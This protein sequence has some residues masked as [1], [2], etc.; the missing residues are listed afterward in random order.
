M[1]E[2]EW[3]ATTDQGEAR[4]RFVERRATDRKLQLFACAV[5]QFLANPDRRSARSD[6]DCYGIVIAAERYAD[7]AITDPEL[8]D[9]M[10]MIQF[11]EES[12]DPIFASWILTGLTAVR[13][14]LPSWLRHHVGASAWFHEV[15]GNPFRPVAFA[16]EWR[17]STVLALAQQMYDARDFSGMPILADAL[18]DAGCTDEAILMHCRGPGPHCRGCWVTDA[19]LNKA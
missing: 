2:A 9:A 16:P 7:G 4:W 15:F 12:F 11:T 17:T 1:T 18:Q 6:D 5:F 10:R 19:L 3:L 14:F 8:T 13:H